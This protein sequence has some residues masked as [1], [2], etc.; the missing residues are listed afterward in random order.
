MPFLGRRDLNEVAFQ[1]GAKSC[2]LGFC[3]RDEYATNHFRFDDGSPSLGFLLRLES[4][5]LGG[6]AFTADDCLELIRTT[7]DDGCHSFLL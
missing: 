4:F 6:M 5:R 7:V 1:R 2:A 3:T